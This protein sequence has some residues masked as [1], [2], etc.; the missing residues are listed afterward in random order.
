M[1]RIR[2]CCGE[3]FNGVVLLL[4]QLWPDKSV[5]ADSLRPIFD[6][7]LVSKS[8]TYVVATDENLVIGFA[9]LTV[10]DNLWPEGHLAYVDELVVDSEHRS[11]GIGAQLLEEL[12][13]I[14]RKKAC[15]RI[16]LDSAF[17]RKDSHR[18]YERKGF[19]KRAFVFSRIL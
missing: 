7:A 2:P 14:A 19:E 16:E 12:A 8:K 18:F 10:K 15:C 1:L 5:D 4:R 13:V 9:S 17:Y 6:R 11:R 3:D